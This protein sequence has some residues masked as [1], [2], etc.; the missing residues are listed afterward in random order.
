MLTIANKG[1]KEKRGTGRRV[2]GEDPE[3]SGGE[4]PSAGVDWCPPTQ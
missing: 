3:T 1:G 2:S 4:V